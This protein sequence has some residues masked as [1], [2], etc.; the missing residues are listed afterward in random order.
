[1]EMEIEDKTIFELDLHEELTV[2]DEELSILIVLR[3][4][5]GW[6]YKQ[7]EPNIEDKDIFELNTQTFVPYNDEFDKNKEQLL[8]S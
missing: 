7:Y 5:G 3:V 2:I 6:I 1:M 4:P 8:G